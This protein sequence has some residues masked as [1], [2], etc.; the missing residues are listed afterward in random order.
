MNE[1]TSIKLIDIILLLELH[2]EVS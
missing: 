1:C 2:A